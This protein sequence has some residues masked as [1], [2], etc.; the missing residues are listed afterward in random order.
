MSNLRAGM[1]QLFNTPILRSLFTAQIPVLLSFGLANALLLPFAIR[2]L[3]ATEFEYGLQEGLTSLG[4]VSGS[5]L[6]A[7]IFDRMR[8]G[9]VDRDQ[10]VGH[11]AG[12]HRV[13]VPAFHS[14]G[15]RRGDHLRLLQ[16][17]VSDRPAAGDPAQHAA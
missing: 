4:F 15:H 5:L 1:K 6:M 9:I 12:G 2:A 8:E 16:R 13:L 7:S 14:A 3:G 17:A 10:L 11:G